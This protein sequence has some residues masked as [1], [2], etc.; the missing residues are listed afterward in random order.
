M[1]SITI[2]DLDDGLEQRLRERAAEQKRSIEE[3]AREILHRALPAA[4]LS[5]PENLADAIRRR[6][7]AA[8]GGIDLE[9]PPRPMRDPPDF[10]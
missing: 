3:E 5:A 8:G 9:L 6:V 7:E 4:M 2:H 1:S 10:R